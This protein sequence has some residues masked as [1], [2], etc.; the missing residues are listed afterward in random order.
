MTILATL[1]SELP[2]QLRTVLRAL[3][4]RI[5]AVEGGGGGGGA[6]GGWQ[7][8]S[9][10]LIT[11]GAH[12]DIAVPAGYSLFELL[13]LGATVA[14]ASGYVVVSFSAD[15][16]AT[17]VPDPIGW[18]TNITNN[19]ALFFRFSPGSASQPVKM[20]GLMAV[21]SSQAFGHNNY[22]ALGAR[23]NVVRLSGLASD[24]DTPSDITG[25]SYVLLGLETPT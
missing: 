17:V 13:P 21:N 24:Y 9:S 10:G 6:S 3:D 25:G 5:T 22:A 14:D 4:T 11:P 15:A 18:C 23:A 1:L 20:A 7:E 16:G 2:R 19:D 12:F 8:V